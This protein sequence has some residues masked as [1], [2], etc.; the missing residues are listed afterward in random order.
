M[1]VNYTTYDLRRKQDSCNS[2]T[3]PDIML[4]ASD[5][6]ASHPYAY[7]RIARLFHLK[8]AYNGPG[9]KQKEFERMDVAW[10]RWFLY[11]L[12]RP[13]SFKAKRL[14]QIRFDHSTKSDSFGFIDPDLIVRATHLI[15]RFSQ[16]STSEYLPPSIARPKSSK[17]TDYRYYFVN[18]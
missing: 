2:E 3:R 12:S 7:T 14:P 8:V 10:V 18:M 17:D 9:Q 16:G 1:R 4:L 11:D 13:F 15:P 6:E 5:S